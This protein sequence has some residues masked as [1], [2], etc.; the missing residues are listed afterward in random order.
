M[1]VGVVAGGSRQQAVDLHDPLGMNK[2]LLP[3]VDRHMGDP[4]QGLTEEQ[5]ISRFQITEP[6]GHRH[7]LPHPGH[8]A[9]IAGQPDIMQPE[10]GLHKA[11]AIKSLG[12]SAAPEIRNSPEATG[13]GRNALRRGADLLQN[14][15]FNQQMIIDIAGVPARQFHSR[16]IIILRQFFQHG[17]GDQITDDLP[18]FIGTFT[19]QSIVAA[20]HQARG[21]LPFFSRLAVGNGQGIFVQPSKI[22]VPVADIIKIILLFVYR[23]HRPQQHLVHQLRLMNRQLPHVRH[24]DVD[25]P[26]TR[27]GLVYP[28]VQHF[29]LLFVCK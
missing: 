12:G 7:L 8:L 6:P 18:G 21:L 20:D 16:L 14:R 4:L 19:D 27:G 28:I 3:E 25:D 13:Q 15:F 22:S 10:H 23:Q 9:G 17:T 11:G 26:V 2:L 1:P 29:Y 5:Q 24:A